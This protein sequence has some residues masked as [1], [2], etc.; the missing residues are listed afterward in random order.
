MQKS[1]ITKR[2][3][4]SSVVALVLCI[5]MLVG[6]T[7][8]WFTDS[9]SSGVNTIHAGNLDV[10]VDYMKP[11]GSWA[12][13]EGSSSLFSDNLWEP[14]HTEVV[15]LRVH[16]AG[17]LA[18]K[19]KVMVTPVS[20]NGGINVEGNPFKLSDY[21]VFGTTEPGNSQTTFADRMAA[22]AAVGNTMGLN[23]ANLTKYGTMEAGSDDQYLALVVYMPESV[24]NEANY[25]TGTAAP[26]IDLGITVVATQHSSESDSFGPSYDIS[27]D[28]RPDNVDKG[29]I[30]YKYTPQV[31]L[32]GA[33]KLNTNDG[34][35]N[36]DGTEGATVNMNG[37][38]VESYTITN[39]FN[40][41]GT[42]FP[43][44]KVTIPVNAIAWPAAVDNT[45]AADVQFVVRADYTYDPEANGI[46][47]T[48]GEAGR[49]LDIKVTGLKSGNTSVLVAE[50]FYEK[51]LTDVKLYHNGV[52]MTEKA[53]KSDVTGKDEFYYDPESGIVTLGFVDCSPFT[54]VYKASE[55]E[56]MI[57]YTTYN[58]I[59]DAVGAAKD[60]DVVVLLKDI[61]LTYF[62]II[63]KN[64]TLDLDN[65]T[66]EHKD[67]SLGYMISV[68]DGATVTVKN[69]TLQDDWYYWYWD[70][71]T[72]DWNWYYTYTVLPSPDAN[73]T[74]ENVNVQ[75][76]YY[77]IYQDD[78]VNITLNNS[79]LTP[80]RSAILLYDS[81]LTIN[82]GTTINSSYYAIGANGNSSVIING[83]TIN[84]NTYGIL[85]YNTSSLVMNGGSISAPNLGM[86][87]SGNSS[88]VMN[89]GTITTESGL[90]L[91]KD[92]NMVMNGGKIVATWGVTLY[93]SDGYHPIATIN[94]G[95]IQVTNKDGSGVT[96]NGNRK[97][98][99]GK[100]GSE[101]TRTAYPA[102]ANING[103]WIHSTF[104]YT[105]E[106]VARDSAV[107]VWGKGA[108]VNVSGTAKL[109]SY[110]FPIV[111]NGTHNSGDYG[112]NSGTKIT[113]S[114]G[115]LTS[116][117]GPAIYHPQYGELT[118]T[119][120]TLTGESSGIEIRAG[121]LTVSGGTITGNG[122]PIETRP[123][124]SGATTYGAGIAI[125]QHTTM[126]PITVN[127]S[128]GTVNGYSALYQSNPQ[129]NPQE[130]VDKVS[131]AVTGGTF[132]AI[133]GGTVA[134]YSENKTGFISGGTFSS[135]PVEYISDISRVEQNSEGMYNVFSKPLIM[136]EAE[137]KDAAISG[138]EA[139]LGVDITLTSDLQ[140][141]MNNNGL[142]LHL[143]GHTIDGGN[144]Q[145]YTQ[146]YGTISIIGGGS[147]KNNNTENNSNRA[148]LYIPIGSVAILDNVTLE[149][150]Y[151]I[152]VNGT[153]EIKNA[154]INAVDCGIAVNYNAQVTIGSITED[155]NVTVTAS[156]GNCISTQAAAGATD[157]NVTIYNGSFTS[158][159]TNWTMCPIYWASHG[160][161]NVYGGTF[162]NGTS[163][164]GAAGLLQKNG[165][166][167]VYG[168]NFAAKDGIK[169]VAQSDST[170][171]VTKIEGGTFT[172]TR[173]G[174][175]IDA[176]NSTYMGR[177]TQYGVSISNNGDS[178]PQF[179]GGS[180]GA[181]YAKTGGLGDRTLMTI[182]GGA[183]SSDPTTYLTSDYTATEE[184]GTWTVVAAN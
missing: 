120:G 71:S 105:D 101:D 129:N 2:A 98:T 25:K 117:M 176:S 119:G 181:I 29:D 115:T 13:I 31:N 67:Y 89:G 85:V 94:G 62:L 35:S 52:A 140:L 108:E 42:E 110:A 66:I 111:G 6:T 32:T 14:G 76:G 166:V 77:C 133:N 128:D 38:S 20:E 148:A 54:A 146:G 114:G 172:G 124:G 88:M 50:V 41:P 93:G 141:G 37:D 87:M 59:H 90:E 49:T 142:I 145:V 150:N 17:S 27:A 22:R 113:I 161:L 96:L 33:L 10:E 132:N 12:S 167:N 151:G 34:G 175:Y 104:A 109:E 99:D 57:G 121:V 70:N 9:V 84:S 82:E 61:E 149:G 137:L 68:D 144:Y 44:A 162:K 86:Q 95:E 154:V 127:I 81:T 130:A 125:A 153:A 65:H 91:L 64:I 28:L 48:D 155:S 164:T 118:V 177:L 26:T 178:V 143:N 78:G 156:N 170:E 168:G 139:I 23:Q 8:A 102:T 56:A 122:T 158:C 47:I 75:G 36:G 53:S 40:V 30:S 173:S 106:T 183:F 73:L 3:L 69:G 160:T 83:G 138:G 171:I 174:I 116:A 79:T 107:S 184:N 136:N 180:E 131:I 169:I 112:D 80:N 60:G 58:T 18:L 51:N 135:D 7:F 159:G 179:I 74:L 100:V 72:N 134:V 46:T 165:T 182:T 19:Y 157:M 152:Y 39:G 92:S 15:Y 16:N 43:N 103:G 4:L 24:G 63:D 97:Y 1:K 55:P 45:Q 163:G 147:I 5:S 123:N 126:L 11:D 21:L